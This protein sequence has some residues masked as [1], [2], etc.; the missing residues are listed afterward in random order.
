MRANELKIILKN[1]SKLITKNQRGQYNTSYI[2]EICGRIFDTLPLGFIL[3]IELD[4]ELGVIKLHCYDINNVLN[5]I[6]NIVS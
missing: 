5:A 3:G 2:N 4:R 1:N 6:I